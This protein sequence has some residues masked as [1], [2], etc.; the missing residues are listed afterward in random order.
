MLTYQYRLYPNKEQQSKLWQHANKLNWLYNY[1]LNQ[2]IESYKQG[3]KIG[4]KEQQLELTQ[5]KTTD[6]IFLEMHSQVLQQVPL[7]LDRSYKAFF[8]RVKVK[9]VAGFPKFRSCEKFFGICYPQAGFRIDNNIFHTKVYGNIEFIKHRELKGEIKQVSISNKN[10]KFYLNIT[11]DYIEN[12]EGIGKIGIDVGLKHLVVA[13][14]G[15]KIKNRTDSK[16][17]DKQISK[18]QSKADQLQ[19]GSQKHKFVKKIISRL[20]DAKV[21]KINDYQHKVSKRLGS[22]YDTIYAEDLSVK[23]MS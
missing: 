13:N 14:D 22:T 15:T 1:F 11:T 2:R 8:R 16:Y 6:S 4:Q 5:L 10:N 19:K 9:E 18:L 17:F 3:I 12:K 21:R 20:Y 23:S 7:R